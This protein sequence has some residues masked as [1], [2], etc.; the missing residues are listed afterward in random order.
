MDRNEWPLWEVFIR[1]RSG[2][3]HKHCGSLHAPEDETRPVISLDLGRMNQ[4]I[5]IDEESGLARIQA[6]AL[7]PD[8]EEQLGAKG[9]VLG[10]YPDSFT[11]STLGGWV[12]TRSSGMQSDKYGDISDIARGMRVVMPGKVLQIRPL[13]HT[14][15][16]PSV[17]EMVLGS[18]G[19]LRPFS[20]IRAQV[21]GPLTDG[22]TVYPG[23]GETPCAREHARAGARGNLAGASQGA[24]GRWQGECR[25]DRARRPALRL[26]AIGSLDQERRR[27]S[28]QACQD[29]IPLTN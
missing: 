17:R 23:P 1:S 12:A 15:T 16:G 19:R 21:G 20:R 28:N 5:D 13:P 3:D 25:A 4:V 11:H 2:L 22:N 27:Q 29:H 14:S 26:P 6:G 18:E 8:L 10:H 9:W 24:A 7:G